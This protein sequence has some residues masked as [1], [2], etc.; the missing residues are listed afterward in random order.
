MPRSA[1][2]NRLK[3]V[4]SPAMTVG[5]VNDRYLWH[6]ITIVIIWRMKTID[7]PAAPRPRLNR[8]SCACRGTQWLGSGCS[9]CTARRAYNGHRGAEDGKGCF[10]QSRAC[11]PWF[12][13]ASTE[14]ASAGAATRLY[15]QTSNVDAQETATGVAPS[16]LFCARGADRRPR[17]Y[18]CRR[19]SVQS[20][21]QALRT[22]VNVCYAC[23]HRSAGRR[24]ARCS[25]P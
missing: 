3:E 1:A 13:A 10:P 2:S 12:M 24:D 20:A 9:R 5:H 8:A 25:L 16:H 23:F 17:T 21:Q 18:Q 14:L 22:W 7:Y 6:M 19:A 11:V 15:S 4:V